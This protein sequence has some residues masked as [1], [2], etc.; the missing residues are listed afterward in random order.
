MLDDSSPPPD[1]AQQLRTLEEKLSFQQRALE[2]LGEVVLAQ[3]AQLDKQGNE[4]TRHR[5]LMDDLLTRSE[6]LPHEKPPHY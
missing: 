1:L 5:K 6:D 4:L 2:E 3:Q